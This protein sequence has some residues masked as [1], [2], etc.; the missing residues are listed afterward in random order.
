MI[1]GSV[2]TGD[3][4][5]HICLLHTL[6][7]LSWGRSVALDEFKTASDCRRKNTGVRYDLFSIS[8]QNYKATGDFE[9]HPVDTV[10]SEVGSDRVST[11]ARLML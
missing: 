6:A 9:R 8:V 1:T 2:L 3:N 4:V 5:W 7:F 10:L 11:D